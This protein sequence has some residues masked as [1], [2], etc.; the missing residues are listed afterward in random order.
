MKAI[1]KIVKSTIVE[2]LF[3]G[4]EQVLKNFYKVA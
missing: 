1:S 2:S 3:T 4:R